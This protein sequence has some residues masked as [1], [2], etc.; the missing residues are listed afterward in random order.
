MGQIYSVCA[1]RREPLD[2]QTYGLYLELSGGATVLTMR[3]SPV[4]VIF[5]QMTKISLARDV[6]GTTWKNQYPRFPTCLYGI[7]L[8]D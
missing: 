1:R 8:W 7:F 6:R 5:T 2:S 3:I 4:N